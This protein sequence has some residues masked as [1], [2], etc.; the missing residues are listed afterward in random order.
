MKWEDVNVINKRHTRVASDLFIYKTN[1]RIT[2][3]EYQEY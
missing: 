2:E 1:K 3:T